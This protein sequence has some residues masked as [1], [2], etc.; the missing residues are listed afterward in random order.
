[1]KHT[2]IIHC[3]YCNSEDLVGNGHSE[4][5]TQLWRCNGCKKNQLEYQN[6]ARKHGIKE[7]IT[8]LTLNSS[9]VRDISRI[10]HINKNTVISELKKLNT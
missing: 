9:G 4:N 6:N 3:L 8:E 1:M 2:Q 5:N 10:L 7:Q